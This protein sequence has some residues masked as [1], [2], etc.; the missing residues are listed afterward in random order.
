MRAIYFSKN[1]S[2]CKCDKYVVNLPILHNAE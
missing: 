1:M 2:K